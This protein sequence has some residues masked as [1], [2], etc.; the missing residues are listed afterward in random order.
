MKRGE[1]YHGA[2]ED[3]E[4]LKRMSRL[5][6]DLCASVVLIEETNRART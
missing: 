3:T 1:I 6:R 2:T 4:A 5:L